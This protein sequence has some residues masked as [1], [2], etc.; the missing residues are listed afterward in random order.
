M[1][2]ER[3]YGPEELSSGPNPT[4]MCSVQ[5]TV[6]AYLNCLGSVSRLFWGWCTNEVP[7]TSRYPGRL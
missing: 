6:G 7:G 5:R 1:T 3:D 2:M 4:L